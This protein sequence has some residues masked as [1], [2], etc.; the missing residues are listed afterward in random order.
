[1]SILEN[2]DLVIHGPSFSLGVTL[3]GGYVFGIE[4]LLELAVFPQSAKTEVHESAPLV[5]SELSRYFESPNF[6]FTMELSLEGTPFQRKVWRAL[7]EIPLGET[8]TYG[9]LASMLGTS[10]R[11][12]GNACRR[13]P[14]P[15]VVPCHR[16]VA[17]HS[18]GGFAGET[19]GA[20]MAIKD[21]LLLHEKHHI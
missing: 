15:I 1:V 14:I 11:A 9:Q 4:F 2:Y 7:Q 16:V 6:D 3:H 19:Q 17:Q 5:Q 8:K 12:V 18:K 21:W 10:P 13:N 20:M